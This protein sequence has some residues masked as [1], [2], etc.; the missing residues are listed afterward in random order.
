MT[1]K[2]KSKQPK[3]F[4]G[5]SSGII[6]VSGS[7]LTCGEAWSEGQTALRAIAHHEA[8]GHHVRVE[9]KIFWERF[10]KP[11]SS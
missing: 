9:Q 2:R 4:S 5:K 10:T 3:K 7:C 8:T 6:T 1:K 11:A